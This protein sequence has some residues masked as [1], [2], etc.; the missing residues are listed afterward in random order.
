MHLA[1]CLLGYWLAVYLTSMVALHISWFVLLNTIRSTIVDGGISSIPSS[2][3][4]VFLF[5][6]T[7]LSFFLGY[8]GAWLIY[9]VHLPWLVAFVYCSIMLVN[10]NNVTQQDMSWLIMLLLAALLLLVARIHLSA[11]LAQWKQEG[12]HT[13]LSLVTRH[14]LAFN[15]NCCTTGD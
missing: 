8:F 3:D 11:Q 1:A 9:R 7:F 10:L 4:M 12:L 2:A 6:L 15:A 5:Y 14:Y 13:D